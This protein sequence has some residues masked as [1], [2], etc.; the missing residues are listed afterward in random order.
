MEGGGSKHIYYYLYIWR[1]E[2]RNDQNVVSSQHGC[3]VIVSNSFRM[4]RHGQNAR[5]PSVS[6]ACDRLPGQHSSQTSA[7]CSR[8]RQLPAGHA[9]GRLPSQSPRTRTAAA[10]TG[11]WHV[12]VVPGLPSNGWQLLRGPHR[13]RL[14]PG[15][16]VHRFAAHHA[17]RVAAIVNLPINGGHLRPC[18]QLV[19]LREVSASEETLRPGN[20]A[21]SAL[22]SSRS[23]DEDTMLWSLS[24]VQVSYSAF[25]IGQLYPI[26]FGDVLL[27]GMRIACKQLCE[28]PSLSKLAARRAIN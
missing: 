4:D 28:L 21:I 18:Q 27:A 23:G 17:V 3:A 12:H 15:L 25:P 11:A 9:A 14:F 24:R 22:P 19:R 13:R 7:L 1:I 10:L 6:L 5:V 16:P 20:Q 2:R 8:E 26:G